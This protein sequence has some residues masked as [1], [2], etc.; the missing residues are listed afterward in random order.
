MGTANIV[1]FSLSFNVSNIYILLCY[2]HY[3]GVF[4][5]LSYALPNPL[6][7][8]I[9]TMVPVV[10]IFPHFPVLFNHTFVGTRFNF[11]LVLCHITVLLPQQIVR[12]MVTPA[13]FLTGSFPFCALLFQ[14]IDVVTRKLQNQWR[15][16]DLPSKTQFTANHHHS[17]HHARASQHQNNDAR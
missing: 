14:V 13:F 8:L 16:M 7:V 5:C 17:T 2:C 11:C 6:F 4:R 3:T 9:V 10:S 15:R 12:R 1:L